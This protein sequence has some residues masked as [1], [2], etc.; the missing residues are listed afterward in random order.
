MKRYQ[1][2][3]TKEWVIDFI[4]CPAEPKIPQ[5]GFTLFEQADGDL[6]LFNRDHIV[7]IYEMQNSPKIDSSEQTIKALEKIIDEYVSGQ[8]A[9]YCMTKVVGVVNDY[10]IREAAAKEDSCQK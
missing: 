10:R 2:G 6:L 3:T 7:F 8:D 5:P 1:I 9:G 4:G